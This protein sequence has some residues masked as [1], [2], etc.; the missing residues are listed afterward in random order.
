MLC[1][2]YRRPSYLC[3]RWLRRLLPA[4]TAARSERVCIS[5]SLFRPYCVYSRTVS[6]HERR[7]CIDAHVHCTCTF[8]PPPD[9]TWSNTGSRDRSP[10]PTLRGPSSSL[11]SVHT[12]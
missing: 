8:L 10:P 2:R 12:T 11:F 5:R 4:P 3:I 1:E 6:S 9:Q 7:R